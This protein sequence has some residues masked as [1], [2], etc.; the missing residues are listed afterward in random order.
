MT[1]FPVVSFAES[2]PSLLGGV[3]YL[4]GL[5]VASVTDVRNRRI[6]NKLVLLMALLGVAF[7]VFSMPPLVGAS[8]ALLSCLIGFALWI[9]FYAL[10]MLGAGDVKLFAAASCWLAPSQVF[11]AALVSALAGGVLSVIGLVL[12]HGLGLTTFRIAYG[13]QNPKMLATPLAVPSGRKTLPYGLAM[14]VGLLVA[15]WFPRWLQLS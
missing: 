9:P 5:I 10:R 15:A 2:V 14:N 11:V 1:S 12:A 3:C 8:R 4:S 7:S 13:L 6:P